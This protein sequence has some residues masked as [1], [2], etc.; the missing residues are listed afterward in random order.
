[1]ITCKRCKTEKSTDQFRYYDRPTTKFFSKKCKA[2]LLE[3]KREW[4]KANF[5]QDN[6][7]NKAYNQRHALRIRGNKLIKYWPGSTWQQALDQYNKL[8]VQ[9]NYKCA[10]CDKMESRI[11]PETGTYWT[12][13]VDHCH[14]TDAVRGLLCNACN[15]GLGL[16]GDSVDS[17]TRVVSYLNKHKKAV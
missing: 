12:L 2:C 7:R 14:I 17:L 13:A 15:R 9:Q 10:L 8:L 1:M 11:H 6:T 5:H 16:L 3:E 4:V